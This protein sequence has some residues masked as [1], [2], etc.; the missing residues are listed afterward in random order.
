MANLIVKI[1]LILLPVVTIAITFEIIARRIPTT[2]NTKVNHFKNKKKQIEILV[3]GSSHSNYG[4]NPQY[5]EREAFNFSNTS[6]FLY[7]DYKV[8]LKYLPECNK[9]KM[10]IIP[11]SYFSLHS[12]LASSPE[13]WR[14]AYYSFYMGVQAKVSQSAFDLKNYSALFLWDGPIE[15]IKG[16]RNS[17]ELNINE[18]GYQ[19]PEKSESN[20]AEIINDKSGKMRVAN[21][22]EIMKSYLFHSNLST[23]DRMAEVLSNRKIKIVFVITPV[24]KTYYQNISKNNYDI[25]INA[26]DKI[27]RK[28]S[29]KSFNYFYDDRFK[30]H[31]FMDNDHLNAEGAKKFSIILKNEV[32]DRLM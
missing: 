28:Y 27:A 26:I 13:A 17:K 4:I 9:I 18:F 3:M 6:Q 31:D 23:L 32:I 16:I 24:Y 19:T 29:A 12:D 7:Q 5:F 2:Y 11:I 14:C 15:L 22:H 10:V 20:I 21:H 30:R 8:L 1:A 25:M